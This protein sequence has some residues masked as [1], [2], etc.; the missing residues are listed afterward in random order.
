M[1]EASVN[2][3]QV[4]QGHSTVMKVSETFIRGKKWKIEKSHFN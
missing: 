4:A 3:I 1:N 2:E